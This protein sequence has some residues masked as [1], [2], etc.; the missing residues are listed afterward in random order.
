MGY[1]RSKAKKQKSKKA[2]NST[3]SLMVSSAAAGSPIA[4]GTGRLERA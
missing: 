2:K 1:D 3:P 4:G